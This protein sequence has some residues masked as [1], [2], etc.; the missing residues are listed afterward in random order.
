M[1]GKAPI[2]TWGMEVSGAW[3]NNKIDG[4]AYGYYGSIASATPSTGIMVGETL[5]TFNPN[6]STWQAIQMGAWMETTKFLNMV[7]S[8]PAELAKLNIPA[9]EVGMANLSYK[10]NS[11]GSNKLT[12]VKMNN[13]KFFA[14]STGGAPKIWTTGDISGSYKGTVSTDNSVKLT[15][16]GLT[17]QFKPT[18][19][20]DGKW[21]ATINNGTTPQTYTGTGSMNATAINFKG[22]GAGTINTSAKTF[23][24]TGAGVVK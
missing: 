22:V 13:V 24:G 23:T 14:P 4:N 10:D 19:W 9:V 20:D 15:G 16:N 8:K 7:T 5:G 18:T 6:D 17:A 21:M 1:G 11:S 12:E 3:A 2:G